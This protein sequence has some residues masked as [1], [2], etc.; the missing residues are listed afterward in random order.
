MPFRYIRIIFLI[1]FIF[2]SISTLFVNLPNSYFKIKLDVY[3]SKFSELFPQRWGFFAPPPKNDY[4][5]VY[6]FFLVNNVDTIPKVEYKVLSEITKKKHY[7][8]PFNAKE[9][10]LD[11]ILNNSILD[12]NQQMRTVQEIKNMEYPNAT[13]SLIHVMTMKEIDKYFFSS[14]STQVMYN[15]GLKL[16]EEEHLPKDYLFRISILQLPIIKFSQKNKE[17]CVQEKPIE[18]LYFSKLFTRNEKIINP[19]LENI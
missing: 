2:Y 5:I 4:E 7:K 1:V 18:L 9:E 6:S 12:L 15:F 17:V 8:K 3:L 11:Y 13:D 19:L 16:A 14:Y 10:I